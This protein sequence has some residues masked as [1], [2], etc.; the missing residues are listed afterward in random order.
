MNMPFDHESLY[1]T[2]QYSDLLS[3]ARTTLETICKLPSSDHQL[4]VAQAMIHADRIDEALEI[5][6][7]NSVRSD[8]SS[9][10]YCELLL[11]LIAKRRGDLEGA[12]RRFQ[13][14]VRLGREA[15]TLAIAA[16]SHLH[17]FRL[18]V[19]RGVQDELAALLAEAR[20]LV[21]SI[22]D[23]HLVSYLH[24]TVALKE[25]QAGRTNEARRH[26][27]LTGS[28]LERH[29]NAWIE[30]LAHINA[31]CVA[32]LDC[33][34]RTALSEIGSA[35]ELRRLTGPSYQDPIID[36]NESHFELWTGRLES[37]FST[38]SRL[39]SNRR[40]VVQVAA[41]D[42]L[43][44][45]YLC[46]NRLNDCQDLL[47]NLVLPEKICNFYTLRWVAY[48]RLALLVRN[49]ETSAAVRESAPALNQARQLSD[50]PLTIALTLLR[51]DAL[52]DAGLV[53]ESA[54]A[55]LEASEIGAMVSDQHGNFHETCHRVLTAAGYRQF[56]QQ[57]RERAL[58]I[59][60]AEGNISS[61]LA[62]LSRSTSGLPLK[63][64]S[65]SAI[66]RMIVAESPG[67]DVDENVQPGF[68]V[69]NAI[70]A[71]FDL[72]ASPNL[73][74]IELNTAAAALGCE[75]SVKFF[76]CR[77]AEGGRDRPVLAS[78]A[79]RRIGDVANAVAV[80]DLLRIAKSIS[81]LAESREEE[82]RRAALWPDEVNVDA[83]GLFLCDEMIRLAAIAK[84]IGTTTVPVLITGETGTGKEILARAIHRESRRANAIF[85]PFNC[86]AG[87]RDMID[88]QLFGHRRGAFTGA[89]EHASGVIRAAAGGT[90]FLDE[91]GESPLE[92]QPKLLRF[93]ESGE[94]HPVGEPHPAKV[95]VR[96][97]AATNVDLDAA[98]SA[99]RFRED[100]FYRLNI[101]RL[102]VPPLRQ[103]RVE[104]PVL[105]LH[106]LRRYTREFAKG[107]LR[108]AEETMEYL[109]LYRWPGN[110]RQLAN[111]MR[112]MAALAETD[113]VLMPEHLS[114]EV[115]A[116]RRTV[117]ASERPL[118]SNE[119]VVRLDQPMAAA[120]EH[121][122]RAI[123][124]WAFRQSGGRV[125]D[126]ARMLGLS[127]KGLYL[128]RQRLGL[129]P[130]EPHVRTA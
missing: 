98:V 54:S 75:Q 57:H 105:A 123:I 127:R 10:A 73:A 64:Y 100:L 42:G 47:R 24:L 114:P 74:A 86:S 66:D 17:L 40:A 113:A 37:A 13:S 50:S 19:E 38:F 31:A 34:F 76:E 58:R 65:Q 80:A 63:N 30:Q 109:I 96:V 11:G 102:H 18:L 126:A 120:A 33:D 59:W 112:R 60:R 124:P 84:R 36:A 95:D 122:E 71:A 78:R 3:P 55:L 89:T 110:V 87:A 92:V 104:I 7:L 115:V 15:S 118:E 69:A 32:S 44:R 70:A 101:V 106:Y 39:S 52:C 23:P 85:L 99:G 12:G 6:G 129:E 61:Q 2:G 72:S 21:T 41:L 51:A 20:T 22:G 53:S 4:M 49:G 117:P 9:Q 29:P 25:A 93:L 28:L 56:G 121:L 119:I 5:I 97:I 26:L 125:E 14:A 79:S 27:A 128:K 16:W 94:V 82:R 83:D 8:R 68:L 130:P 1:R 91:I 108:L 46:L 103:R 111:E 48:T 107:D 35:R 43:A 77:S 81:V 67:T 88:A 116:G 62:L 45:L 90:L